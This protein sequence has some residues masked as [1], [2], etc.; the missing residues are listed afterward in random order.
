[1]LLILKRSA[2]ENNLLLVAQLYWNQSILD[3]ACL[4]SLVNM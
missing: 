2:V 4:D 1:M 3:T